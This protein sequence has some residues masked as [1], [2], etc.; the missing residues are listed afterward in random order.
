MKKELEPV[1]Q[2]A[3]M[4]AEADRKE[5]EHKKAISL[6]AKSGEAVEKNLVKSSEDEAASRPE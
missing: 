1:K 5:K 4:H 6:P 2:K 3:Q